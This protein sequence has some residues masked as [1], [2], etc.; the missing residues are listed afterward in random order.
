MYTFYQLIG[1]F[2]MAIG[3]LCLV[4]TAGRWIT[5]SVPRW[6][7]AAGAIESAALL[8]VGLYLVIDHA[9]LVPMWAALAICAVVYETRMKRQAGGQA[10]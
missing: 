7:V 6:K 8:A 5:R 1:F 2:T 10:A 9:L 3:I 4:I